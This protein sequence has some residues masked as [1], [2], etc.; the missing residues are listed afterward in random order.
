[1]NQRMIIPL[2]HE[3]TLEIGFRVRPGI[4]LSIQDVHLRRSGVDHKSKLAQKAQRR[5]K[6]LF[7][8]QQAQRHLLMHNVLV[9]NGSEA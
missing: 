7:L 4:P 9:E 1:M 2:P 8:F 3:Y 5:V 6:S